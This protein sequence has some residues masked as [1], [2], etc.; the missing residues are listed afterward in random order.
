MIASKD[1]ILLPVILCIWILFSI[2]CTRTQQHWIEV[3]FTDP[4]LDRAVR[5]ATGFEGTQEGPIYLHQ[6]QNIRLISAKE[7]NIASLE[8]LQHLIHLEELY[9]DWN[10]LD[11]LTPIQELVHLIGLTFSQNQVTD[12]KPLENLRSLV[13]RQRC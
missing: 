1:R 4:N 6:L 8:G 13:L 11:D 7:R 9:L 10:L 2:S 3:V 12:I 5:E